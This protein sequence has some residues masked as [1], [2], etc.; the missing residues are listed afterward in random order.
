M[1][2][3]AP[4]VPRIKRFRHLGGKEALCSAPPLSRRYYEHAY[5]QTVAILFDIVKVVHTEYLHCY[6]DFCFLTVESARAQHHP[7]CP[8]T[9]TPVLWP[10]FLVMAILKFCAS[11]ILGDPFPPEIPP[12]EPVPFANPGQYDVDYTRDL[13]WLFSDSFISEHA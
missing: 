3:S 4:A 7:P 13:G 1:N 6:R 11:L 12:A 10:G 9:R 2:L 8:I 5:L